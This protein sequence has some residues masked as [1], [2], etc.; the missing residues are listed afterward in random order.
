MRPWLRK[1]LGTTLAFAVIVGLAWAD[2][3]V[4]R[5]SGGVPLRGTVIEET[6][7][8]VTIQVKSTG[9]SEKVPVNELAKM[10]YDGKAGQAIF[11]AETSYEKGGEY[12]KLADA[13]AKAAQEEDPKGFAVRAAQF[14]RARS[15]VRL[16]QRDPNRTDDAIK[17]LEE[18]RSKNPNSRFHYE[19]HELLGQLHLR[20]GNSESASAAF[21]ALAKAPWPDYKLKAEVYEGRVQLAAGHYDEAF[22]IFDVVSKSAGDSAE[23]KLRRQ[24]AQLGKADC[25]VKQKKHAEAEKLLGEVIAATPGDESAVQATA[26]NLLGDVLRETGKTKEA[27]RSYLYVDLLYPGERDEHAKALC[28]LALLWDQTR[29]DRAADFRAKLK[30]AYPNSP[31]L[32]LAG[33]EA[34]AESDRKTA[35]ETKTD[36]EPEKE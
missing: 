2:D 4:H 31:W 22:L 6:A 13:Y 11:Q 27:I 33:L 15:I 32:K 28:Y 26:H 36:G 24:E 30:D 7:D 18:F 9:K 20:K 14:G 17:E 21:A 19:L 5:R 12:Q 23:E 3:E 34:T 1:L 16:A 29:P 25:L 35:N 8:E 10:K